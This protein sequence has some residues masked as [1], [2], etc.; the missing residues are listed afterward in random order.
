K[1]FL[2]DR[3]D[4]AGQFLSVD[5][6]AGV[7]A[8][9]FIGKGAEIAGQFFVLSTGYGTVYPSDRY[10]NEAIWTSREI[11]LYGRYSD[12]LS[13]N[14]ASSLLVQFRH[15]SVATPSYYVYR[16]VDSTTQPAPVQMEEVESPN[17][18]V[19]VTQDFDITAAQ[20]LLLHGDRL[21]FGTGLKYE[22]VEI[23]N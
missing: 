12:N 18:G 5:R 13:P 11:T 1:Q 2:K 17:L 14:V 22:H 23:N 19:V 9:V 16:N 20:S 10:Q 8:R 6:K 21:S 15:S 3:P 4:L 7:D